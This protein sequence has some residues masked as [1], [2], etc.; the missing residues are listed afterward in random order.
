M[1]IILSII[2]LLYY[3]NINFISSFSFIHYH[4]TERKEM[5]GRNDALTKVSRS[6]TDDE[7][8]RNSCNNFFYNLIS[9]KA[10]GTIKEE[11]AYVE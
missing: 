9:H 4:L 10:E 5:D 1:L 6:K 7:S 8:A 2:Y 11:I 3:R